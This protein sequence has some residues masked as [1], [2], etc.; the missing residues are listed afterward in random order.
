MC[1]FLWDWQRVLAVVLADLSKVLTRV[2]FGGDIVQQL[3]MSSCLQ[4]KIGV[5]DLITWTENCHNETAKENF[6]RGEAV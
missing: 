3:A 5:S 6:L 4:S 2:L 1:S